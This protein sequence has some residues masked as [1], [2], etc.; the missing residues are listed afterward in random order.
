MVSAFYSSFLAI[1]SY[2]AVD[3]AIFSIESEK[4]N[5]REHVFNPIVFMSLVH[6]SILMGI[7]LMIRYIF[8]VP[9]LILGISISC[10]CIY[11]PI[12]SVIKYLFGIVV[13]E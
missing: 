2:F 7:L 3:E 8:V 5:T 11:S 9:F 4:F 1:I 10:F 6:Y 13:L 12:R